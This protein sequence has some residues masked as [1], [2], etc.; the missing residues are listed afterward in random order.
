[1]KHPI[2]TCIVI[3]LVASAAD[4]QTRGRRTVPGLTP[5]P[6]DE[7]GAL[8]L[9]PAPLVGGTDT[10]TT[11]DVIVG[12]GQF[13]FDNTTATTGTEGQAETL[14][15]QF[16]FY[17]NIRDVW[18]T[19]TAPAT[20]VVTVNT[21]GL[22][23]IDT[24]IGIY[25]GTSCPTGPAL[26]CN[27]D[28]CAT[29]F[30]TRLTFTATMG[31]SYV[32]QLGNSEAPP[33]SSPGVGIFEL[34]QSVL[35]P[36]PAND[37]CATPTAL[38]GVGTYPFDNTNAT[39]G[40]EGQAEALCNLTGAGTT[41]LSDVWYTWTASLNGIAT[42]N[43]CGIS[44]IDTKIAIY[45]GAGCPTASAIACNDDACA[46]YQST[47]QFPCLSGNT[48][49]IQLGLYPGQFP[50]AVAGA[51]VFDVSEQMAP[52]HD[53]CN[54]PVTLV[55]AGPFPFDN[56]IASTGTQGQTEA[57]CSFFGGTAVQK[58][59]WYTWQATYTGFAQVRTC[60]QTSVDTKIAVYDGAGCPTAS[61]IACNDDACSSLQTATQF[62]CTVGQLY[63]FQFGLYYGT[64]TG[65]TGT[66]DIFT[67]PPP[68][69]NDDCGTAIAISGPGPF[70]YD[71]T[72][73]TTGVQGQ[74]EV[75]CQPFAAGPAITFDMW[76]TWTP[77]MT[78]TATLTTC[79]GLI[80]SPAQD[81]KCAIY[82]DTSCPTTAAI[83]CNDD[84]TCAVATGLNTTVTWSTTCGQTYT[85]QIGRYQQS[86]ANV[87]SFSISESGGPCA[88]P[89]VGYCFGDDTGTL[90][91]CSTNLPA[92]GT[93]PPGAPGNGCPNSLNPAGA[94]L[95]SSG[96]SVIS[97]DTFV[98]QG[99]GMPNASA[100]YFQ[101]TLKING[102]NGIVFGDGLRCVGGTVIRLKTVTNVGGSSSYPAVGDL[103]ISI[104]G[105][106]APPTGTGPGHYFYQCWY[107]NAALFCQ[108]NATF[109]LTNGLDVDWQP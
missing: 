6:A 90:C 84:F 36:P 30:Q 23:G 72:S 56:T 107:R 61:A 9:P 4:A 66:F 65:G 77:S 32:I 104:K 109:N 28:N 63:T 20:G 14:C 41:L 73:A 88:P 2:L 13:Q 21:C 37:V 12:T 17:S 98:L 100:L 102:G 86:G 81:S 35:G 44:T 19:W 94:H 34:Q 93:V 79:G 68:P 78:G 60:G 82:A 71:N 52:A 47:V 46:G 5:K 49:T 76:Y 105:N 103:P 25:N 96:S 69:P 48:Y 15:L 40:T 108:V 45:N 75:V 89:A 11:P 99:S 39:T 10:C 22:T 101:G 33:P 83:A 57:L 16:G 70:A 85:I 95:G 74:N 62:A 29:G 1:M 53:D 91:P 24:K 43:T 97:A 26:A 27:D 31:N 54:S 64:Q 106:L 18:F 42:V 7:K 59:L 50:P 51:G 87:G 38:P 58:D 80:G 3:A 67:P 55:G 8:T 92:P